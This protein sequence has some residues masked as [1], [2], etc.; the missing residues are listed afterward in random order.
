MYYK[1]GNIKLR[2]ATRFVN[3]I[4]ITLKPSVNVYNKQ[5]S[6]TPVRLFL[7]IYLILEGVPQRDGGEEHLQAD[8]EVL[9]SR[10][11][12]SHSQRFIGLPPD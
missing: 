8:E 10:R 9:N 11:N 5:T 2:L 4:C 3:I 7:L 1:V 6:P 12:V